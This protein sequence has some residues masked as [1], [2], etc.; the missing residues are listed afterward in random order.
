MSL[1]ISTPLLRLG[2]LIALI[3]LALAACNRLPLTTPPP[4]PLPA[5]ASPPPTS[6]PPPTF[7]PVLAGTPVPL[8]QE[9]ITPDNVDQ[10]QQLAMWGKGRIEQL[11]YSPDGKILAVGTTAGVWLYDAETLAELRFINTGNFVGNLAFTEDGREL[12]TDV[13][14]STLMTWDVTTGEKLDSVRVRDG[15]VSSGAGSSPQSVFSTEANLLAATLDDYTVSLWEVA[16]GKHIQTVR[17]NSSLEN[18]AI[19]PDGTLLATGDYSETTIWEVQTGKPSYSLPGSKYS[20]AFSTVNGIVMLLTASRNEDKISLWDARSGIMVKTLDEPNAIS[21]ASFSPDGKLLALS[22]D[23]EIRLWRITDGTLLQTWTTGPKYFARN[24]V[25]SPDSKILNSG[26]PDGTVQRW[27]TDTGVWID[28]LE[29]FGNSGGYIYPYLVPL[30]AFLSKENVFISNPFN[31]HIDLWN[32]KDGEIV[33]TLTGHKSIILNLVISTDGSKLASTELW[34]N[35]VRIWE[36]ATGQNLGAYEVYIDI[37]YNKELAISPNGQLIAIGDARAR[38]RKVYDSTDLD[39][40]K[41]QLTKKQYR[42]SDPVFSPDGQ[43]IAWFPESGTVDVTMTVSKAATGELLH[44]CE[45]T[46]DYALTFAP[47][48][49]ILAVGTREGKIQFC[50]SATGKLVNT[51]NSETGNEVVSLAYSPDGRILAAGIEDVQL[52]FGALTLTIWLWDVKT[53]TLLKTIEGYQA[54]IVYLA[55]SP[56]GALLATASLDGTMRLWGIPPK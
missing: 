26:S 54:N 5:L 6:S 42:R 37:G 39:N 1:S 10:I 35:T 53:G 27:N 2:G 33:K 49:R 22:I 38:Q 28:K 23:N 31:Y 30:P 46:G 12:V 3:L 21:S 8:P 40:Q 51:L 29:G 20:L 9:P 11:A 50:D 36:P 18:L 13:G 41:Y 34:T 56:D 48:S 19:S 43:K 47:D 45:P 17:S 44:T 32:L 7:S 25:F 55:F 4:T 14:A 15:F 52:R 16:T 24:L